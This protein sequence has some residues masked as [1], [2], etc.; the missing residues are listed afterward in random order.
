MVKTVEL[1]HLFVYGSL[2]PGRPNEGMFS[3]IQGGSQEG[4][5]K[6]RLKNEVWGAEIGFPGIVLD[7]NAVEVRGFIFSSDELCKIL[8]KL[9]EFEGEGYQCALIKVKNL[10]GEILQACI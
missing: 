8:P 10:D 5:V 4:C 1:M 3:E 6:G 9:Y 7:G 2:G